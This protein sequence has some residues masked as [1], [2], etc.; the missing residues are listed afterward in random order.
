MPAR[1]LAMPRSEGSRR[2]LTV[3]PGV[4]HFE[5][6]QL[7]IV[8]AIEAEG[9]TAN[10]HNHLHDAGR[11]QGCKT[12]R[13]EDKMTRGQEDKI[14]S[15]RQSNL[16]IAK[17]YASRWNHVESAR[18]VVDEVSRVTGEAGGQEAMEAR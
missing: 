15:P 8:D 12:S 6:R 13:Q 9:V 17:F 18:G 1:H 3:T 4:P 5:T 11:V 14:E 7:D 2:R 16:C 10:T